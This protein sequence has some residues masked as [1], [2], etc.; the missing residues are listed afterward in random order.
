MPRRI[1]F[2]ILL[3]IAGVAGYVAGASVT[4]SNPTYG[5]TSKSYTLGYSASISVNNGTSTL[6]ANTSAGMGSGPRVGAIESHN[7]LGNA[8]QVVVPPPNTVTVT[9]T[10]TKT[11]T[12]TVTKTVTGPNG[13]TTV[14][15]QIRTVTIPQE[16]QYDKRILY[17]AGVLVILFLLLLA[18]R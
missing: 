7:D 12:Y 9:N 3:I 6:V 13:E 17:G 8:S 14:I 2:L 18:K 15:T 16:Q 1:L 4:V 10:T 5:D 11:I